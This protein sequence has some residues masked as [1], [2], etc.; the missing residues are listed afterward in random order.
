MIEFSDTPN[1]VVAI[2]S[3]VIWNSLGTWYPRLSSGVAVTFDRFKHESR[4]DF[5]R[6]Q[7]AREKKRSALDT[8]V[9]APREEAPRLW[10]GEFE[11]ADHSLSRAGARL[12]YLNAI[13]KVHP[14]VLES[15]ADEPLR[16][17]RAARLHEYPYQTLGVVWEDVEANTI[18]EEEPML[19][20]MRE[21][22]WK[23]AIQWHLDDDW[24]RARAF[25]TLADWCRKPD[26]LA[27]LQ[28][29]YGIINWGHD[30]EIEP[31]TFQWAWN[32]LI[33]SRFVAERVMRAAFDEMM[34]E[35]FDKTEAHAIALGYK[36]ALRKI[37]LT[38]FE[39]LVSFHI[40]GM[41]YAQICEQENPKLYANHKAE[42]DL[43][44]H[45]KRIKKAINLLAKLMLLPLDKKRTAPGRRRTP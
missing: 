5:I 11:D 42:G 1:R 21:S 40:K 14:P 33:E 34:R 19:A 22:L 44:D 30:Y 39:W 28:W 18:S 37:E 24:F 27:K 20:P 32:P 26:K 15:L 6:K 7:M 43:G 12:Y 13:R 23:W 8:F 41:T 36:R 25:F 10:Q 17:F 35:Y 45:A 2:V 4:V 29:S 16:C 38:H 3:G 9:K 31:F